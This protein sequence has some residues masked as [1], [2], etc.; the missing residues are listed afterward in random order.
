MDEEHHSQGMDWRI[1]FGLSVTSLWIG[2]GLIYLSQIVGWTNFV[3]LPTGEIGSFFEGA[4]APLAFLWLVIGHFM[5]QKEITA[6]TRAISMQERSTRRL[7]L[8]SRRDSYFKLLNLVQDQLGNIASFHYISVFGPTGTGEVD[9]E[10]FGQL[11]SESSTGDHSLFVRRMVSALASVADEPEKLREILYG[12]EIRCRHSDNFKNTF[13]KLLAAADSVD[14][15]GMVR[16]ALIDGSSS[17]IYYK[18]LRYVSGEDDMNPIS[19]VRS[20]TDSGT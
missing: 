19:G 17:G 20:D 2:A 1:I 10:E 6:N 14:A 13:G 7:E 4:F 3:G 8:H 5:Q 16:D 18:I 11:R 9:M 15:D 12:T